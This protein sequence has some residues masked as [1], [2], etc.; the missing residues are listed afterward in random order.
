MFNLLTVKFFDQL[1]DVSTC[2]SAFLSKFEH[3]WFDSHARCYSP[4]VERYYQRSVGCRPCL[5]DKI[6]NQS[7]RCSTRERVV[8]S[9][10]N[11]DDS[12]TSAPYGIT[13]ALCLTLL[14]TRRPSLLSVA[15]ET[16]SVRSTP[17][18]LLPLCKHFLRQW[19][20]KREMSTA[21][22][23]ERSHSFNIQQAI[24]HGIA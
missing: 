13:I 2:S 8:C 6:L 16:A 4:I 14:S 21:W 12:S 11:R 10:V 24:Y 19:C 1:N 22:Q 7:R 5:Q 15:L 3:G 17:L 23:Y 18:E 20:A 9:G